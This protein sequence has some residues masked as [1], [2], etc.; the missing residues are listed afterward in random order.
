MRALLQ[1]VSQANVTVAGEVVAH[2]ERGLLVYVGV[3]HDDEPADAE[4]L[5]GKIRYVRIFPDES[6]KM[7][8]DVL[9]AGGAALVVSNFTLQADCGQGRRPAFTPAAPPEAANRLYELLCEKLLVLGVHVQKGRF[10]QSMRVDAINEGP[11]N[12]ILESRRSPPNANHP[13]DDEGRKP[14]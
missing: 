9:Q 11:I 3:A 7:N 2:I 4:F 13:A 5:A 1:R 10:G 6:D 8:L 14:S 12:F